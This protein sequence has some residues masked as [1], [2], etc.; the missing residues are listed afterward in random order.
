MG[1]MDNVII[2]PNGWWESDGDTPHLLVPS[3]CNWTINFLKNYKN[4]ALHDFGCGLGHYLQKISEA[5]YTNLIGYEG[6]RAKNSVFN[7]I[8]EQDI[9]E[10]F[11]VSQ[12]GNV[13]CFEVGEHIP[14]ELENN[15]L[16]NLANA[17]E[18]N[19]YL[20]LSW[21]V[22][23]QDYPGHVNMLD[24]HEV[25]PKLQ[26]KGFEFLPIETYDAK[27]SINDYLHFKNVMV[28]KKKY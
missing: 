26:S 20:I 16:I 21:A 27:N 13:I 25:I 11:D 7:N 3:I 10:L 24:N 23:G 6:K 12:K 5:G 17:C 14:V 18:K 28:Y 15:L 22:R 19:H 8:I 4:Q 2:H 1:E 9:T